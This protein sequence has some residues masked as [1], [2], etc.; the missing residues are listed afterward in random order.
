MVTNGQ[1]GLQEVARSRVLSGQ[2][3][4][5]HPLARMPS[6]LDL[7]VPPEHQELQLLL[8]LQGLQGLLAA[9]VPHLVLG[10]RLDMQVL[11]ELQ[12][13]LEL[14]EVLEGQ[15]LHQARHRS[16]ERLV[17][18]GHHQGRVGPQERLVPPERLGRHQRQL[19]RPRCYQLEGI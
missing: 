15:A 9:Q 19:P 10:V 1:P 13:L 5:R 7:Q 17:H 11:L 2:R 14:Q 4:R 12:G 6:V 18:L 16:Q 3:R 8:E